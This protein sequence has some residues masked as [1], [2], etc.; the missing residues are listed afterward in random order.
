[1]VERIDKLQ[2]KLFSDGHIVSAY[3]DQVRGTIQTKTGAITN[4]ETTLRAALDAVKKT[5]KEPSQEIAL[6]K[7]SLGENLIAQKR[8][9]EARVV[10]SE[11]L[12]SYLKT[13]GPKHHFTK[14]CSAMLASIP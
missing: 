12:E 3:L 13:R 2:R 5:Y 10:L 1:M 7:H 8:F 14:D 11:A 9:T 6:V 4:G